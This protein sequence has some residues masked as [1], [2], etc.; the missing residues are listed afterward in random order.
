VERHPDY[1]RVPGLL[2]MRLEAPIFYANATLVR[3]RVKHLVG[4]SDPLPRAMILELIANPALDITSAEML[5]HLVTTL[6]AAGVDVALAART[7]SS[8]RSPT[9]LSGGAGIRTQGAREGTTVFKSA[10]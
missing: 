3:D 9:P 2:V 4:S 7:G 8:S 6:R 1:Q 10:G 5:E